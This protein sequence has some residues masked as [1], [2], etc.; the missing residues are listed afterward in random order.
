MLTFVILSKQIAFYNKKTYLP[1]EVFYLKNEWLHE[2]LFGSFICLKFKHWNLCP[3]G[4]K[5]YQYV[6]EFSCML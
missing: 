6:L 5:N 2:A 1:R 4:F 3:V